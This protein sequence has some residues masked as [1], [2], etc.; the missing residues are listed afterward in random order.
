MRGIL[1]LAALLALVSP[2]AADSG[3][4]CPMTAFAGM[5]AFE[6]ATGNQIPH[7]GQWFTANFTGG[8]CG[9]DE[10]GVTWTATPEPTIS[11]VCFGAWDYVVTQ[12]LGEKRCRREAG[13]VFWLPP[14]TW[15]LTACAPPVVEGVC[16]GSWTLVDVVVD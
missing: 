6:D 4:G 1:A 8:A 2:A 10:S 11:D 13:K 7:P 3:T 14:G 15:T 5:K 12:G 16:K 9:S